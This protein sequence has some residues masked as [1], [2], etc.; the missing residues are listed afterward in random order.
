MSASKLFIIHY[1]ERPAAAMITITSVNFIR[2]E[3]NDRLEHTAASAVSIGCRCNLIA[4]SHESEW[5]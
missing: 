2:K 4:F 5:S 3:L 1:W